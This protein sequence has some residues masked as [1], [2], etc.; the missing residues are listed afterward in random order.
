MKTRTCVRSHVSTCAIAI[1]VRRPY[2]VLVHYEYVMA[3]GPIQY[4]LSMVFFV[5]YL[6]IL[7]LSVVFPQYI[8]EIFLYE[9]SFARLLSHRM[10][11]LLPFT[12][13]PYYL[14]MMNFAVRKV[15]N[16]R[17]CLR[18]RRCGE[19]NQRHYTKYS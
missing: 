4:C 11:V 13:T 12:L 7:K 1:I 14:P 2:P 19:R 10:V 3:I 16:H 6:S 17:L 8:Y 18:L 5:K 15:C 9:L